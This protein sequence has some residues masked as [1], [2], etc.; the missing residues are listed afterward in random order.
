MEFDAPSPQQ[1]SGHDFKADPLYGKQPITYK[2][3][4]LEEA[5]AA[6]FFDGK[7]DPQYMTQGFEYYDPETKERRKLPEFT[8]YVLGV[9]YGSFSNG[10]GKGDIRYSTNLVENTT[11]D[12]LQSFYFIEQKR[13]VL[14][15]GNYKRDIC[16]ALEKEG[17]KSG[18]YTRVIVAY[19]AEMKEV[20]AIHLGAT[21][22]AGF[23]KAIATARNIPEHKA[24]LYGLSDLDSEIWVFK[25]NGNFEPVIFAPKDA[26]NSAATV[27]AKKG[28]RKIYFQPAILAGVI[29]GDN[30]KYKEAFA[31]VS[32]MRV[33][34]SDYIH[35]EQVYL[36]ARYEKAVATTP[37]QPSDANFPTQEPTGGNAR[38]VDIPEQIDG[39]DL[40]F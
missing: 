17:R 38:P 36:R 23:V 26:R 31:A 18:G 40:P 28:N 39:L 21:A 14:A 16:P 19:I 20:R 30:P 33:E 6:M 22:E 29:R 2:A 11:T 13:H 4:T 5:S 1:H 7:L 37:Q 35:S 32:A 10:E 15:V 8:A 34:Y 24:S 9:Y 3:G 27:P 12:I 25:F